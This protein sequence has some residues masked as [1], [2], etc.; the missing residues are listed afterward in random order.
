MC[1]LMI[2]HV[3]VCTVG[4]FLE[5]WTLWVPLITHLNLFIIY[6]IVS[7]GKIS[8]V[9][10]VPDNSGRFS[11]CWR[12]EKLLGLLRFRVRWALCSVDSPLQ[13]K[14]FL[15]SFVSCLIQRQTMLLIWLIPSV[16]VYFWIVCAA[17]L[18][19][20]TRT[21]MLLSVQIKKCFNVL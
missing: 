15:H 10:L 21:L 11:P 16:C 2:L 1:D 9:V 4:S 18:L 3:N 7:N 14:L 19:S 5:A 20:D 6:A 17:V 12:R 13:V 8:F